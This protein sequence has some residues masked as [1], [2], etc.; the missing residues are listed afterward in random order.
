MDN[1]TKYIR[2]LKAERDQ[3]D[4]EIA[5]LE[6]VEGFPARRAVRSTAHRLTCAARSVTARPEYRRTAGA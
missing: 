5:R 4:A 6:R 3:L 1:L 2:S